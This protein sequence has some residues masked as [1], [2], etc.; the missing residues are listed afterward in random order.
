VLRGGSWPS[1]PAYCRS[2]SRLQNLAPHK[3]GKIGSFGFRVVVEIG[4]K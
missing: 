1:D 4:T 3:V 2:A